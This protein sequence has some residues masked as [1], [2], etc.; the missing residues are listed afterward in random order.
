[1]QPISDKAVVDMTIHLRPKRSERRPT[2]KNPIEEPMVQMVAAQ[3]MLRDGPRSSLISILRIV[4][5]QAVDVSTTRNVGSL[6]VC[7]RGEP[8][9]DMRQC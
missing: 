5:V 4:S 9:R 6:T 2:S 1:M 8:S 3:P 7:L